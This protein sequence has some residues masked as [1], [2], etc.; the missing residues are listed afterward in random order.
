MEKIESNLMELAK[1]ANEQYVLFSRENIVFGDKQ[2][3]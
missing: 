3:E 1:K 2:P